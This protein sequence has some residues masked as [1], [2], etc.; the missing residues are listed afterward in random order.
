[1][2]WITI[3]S[4]TNEKKTSSQGKTYDCTVIKGKK[5]GYP[6]GAPDEDWSKNLMPWKDGPII[7]KFK[8]FGPGK[9]VDV[10]SEKVGNF[11]NIVSVEAVGGGGGGGT[12]TPTPEGKPAP[13]PTPQGG[14]VP[15]LYQAPAAP[16]DSKYIGCL[17]VA[18]DLII[19]SMEQSENFKNLIKRSATPELVKQMVVDFANHF[20][21][22]DP[23]KVASPAANPEGVKPEAGAPE[24]GAPG[25]DEVPI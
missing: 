3:E 19:K 16:G 22:N 14:E 20:Y 2:A 6:K 21:V 11:W 5:K 4:I 10:K 1:M 7:E 8:S 15:V 23:E 12:P 9:M 25:Q 13:A 18:S 24:G 17:R